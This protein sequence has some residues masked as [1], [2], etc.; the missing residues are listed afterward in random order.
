LTS[1]R[2]S[3]PS[4]IPGKASHSS[5]CLE[6]GVTHRALGLANPKHQVPPDRGDCFS[7]SE[8]WTLIEVI[9]RIQQRLQSISV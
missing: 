1:S 9:Q 4:L 5:F 8:V 6:I 7:I 2:R 3:R